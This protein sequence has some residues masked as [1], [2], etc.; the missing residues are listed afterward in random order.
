MIYSLAIALK[1]NM[2]EFSEYKIKV[3]VLEEKVAA[4]E[5]E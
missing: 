2:L 5:I 3:T 4:L 1:S